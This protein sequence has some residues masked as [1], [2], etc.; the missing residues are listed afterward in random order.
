M[1]IVINKCY[2][3]FGISDEAAQYMID[4]GLV[5]TDFDPASYGEDW[6]EY[7][8]TREKSYIE[9]NVKRNDPLL[10]QAVEELGEKSF[11]NHA[12]LRIVEIPDDVEWEIDDYDG[13][14]SVAEKH[15]RWG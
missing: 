4:N 14:E 2:G 12:R 5:L 7:L 15:R 8:G 1:K 9:L 6:P 10:I 3:G 13:M 11:G